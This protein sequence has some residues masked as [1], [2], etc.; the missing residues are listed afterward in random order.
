MSESDEQTVSWT[1]LYILRAIGNGHDSVGRIRRVVRIGRHAL[2]EQI[3]EVV[4]R[5]FIVREG[6]TKRLRLTPQGVNTLTTFGF[7]PDVQPN[8][9]PIQRQEIRYTTNM[10]TGFSVAFGLI[11]GLFLGWL[12]LAALS[13]IIFW[14]G[15]AFVLKN[16]VPSFML[17]YV[18]L[19]NFVVDLVLGIV[20]ATAVFLPVR[21]M[22]PARDVRP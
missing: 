5:G 22:L 14:A 13:S 12:L 1:E 21:R 8:Q 9:A 2:Q 3:D 15:Y 7:Q 4:G 20:T 10:R 11:T 6:L 17:P 16:Y 19:D 18:P